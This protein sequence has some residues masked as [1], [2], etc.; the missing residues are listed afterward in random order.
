[1]KELGVYNSNVYVSARFNEGVLIEENQNVAFCSRFLSALAAAAATFLFSHA[2]AQQKENFATVSNERIGPLHLLIMINSTFYS[3]EAL[4]A[5]KNMEKCWFKC[6]FFVK[7]IDSDP[8]FNNILCLMADMFYMCG[9][10]KESPWR[11]SF[12]WNISLLYII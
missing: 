6:T 2:F 9:G 10:F 8:F 7:I 11:S 12:K 1:M 3:Y 5:S 4:I